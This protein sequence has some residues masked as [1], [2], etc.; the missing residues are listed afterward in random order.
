MA[1]TLL[2]ILLVTSAAA[3][4][5]LVFRWPPAPAPSAR[6]ARPRPDKKTGAFQLDNPGR[7][8]S[9]SDTDKLHPPVA[10]HSLDSDEDYEWVRPNTI[11]DRS[12]SFSRP[13]TGQQS[14]P[15]EDAAY[16]PEEPT[17]AEEFDPLFGYSSEF[18]AGLLCPRR[19]LCHQKF[20]LIVDDLAFIGHPVCA[21]DDEIWRFKPEKTKRGSSRG[22]GSR[23]RQLSQLDEAD[24]Q[25]TSTGSEQRSSSSPARLQ[26]FHLVI[27]LDLP[28]KS[29][30]SSGDVAKYF[31][32][33]YEQIA[34]TVTA[35][36]FQ[37]QVLS[38]FVEK[39]CDKLASLKDE[40]ASNCEP[41]ESY[42]DHALRES[43]IAPAIK[44]LYEAIKSS[45]M[46]HITIHNIPIELQLPPYLDHLLHSEDDY[47][48]DFVDRQEDDDGGETNAWDKEMGFG[49]R[50]PALAPW[51]SLLLLD[52]HSEQTLDPQMGV[53][54]AQAE[55]GDH[56]LAEGL[57][58][59]LETTSVTLSL[60]DMASLLDWDL[61]S[62][63]YP[64]V[65][66]LVLHRRAKIVDTVHNGLKTVFTIAPK[67][68]TH[69]SVLIQDFKRD[70]PQSGVMPLAKILS[71]ISTSTSKQSDNHFFAAVVKSK[72]LVGLYHD[73]VLWMLKRD[74]LITLHLRI[75]VV[76]TAE[77]KYHVRMQRDMQ[78]SKR[79][80]RRLSSFGAISD[81]LPDI[82][83]NL[84]PVG[85]LSW[86][87]L[88]PK[89]ARRQTRRLPSIGSGYSRTSELLLDDDSD[90]GFDFDDENE[91]DAD[92][93]DEAGVG[94]GTEEDTL[95]P[96]MIS[97]PGRATPLQRKWLSAMSEDKEEHIAYRFD[98]I[99][100]YFDGKRTDDEILHRAEI[101]RKQ[102]REVLHHY[103][104]YL[105]TFLHPS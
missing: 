21:E 41:L 56:A 65:R 45:T 103:E 38:N 92:D 24:D 98:Q 94:W 82:R 33:I 19:S 8:A 105:Q 67:F 83:G 23:N 74:L 11:R 91:K 81:T 7:A 13:S 49:W 77:I 28:D 80:R 27:V 1:E 90:D 87:S 15:S 62:Q 59:F 52:N 58:K 48:L 9:F 61:E 12:M 42:M 40:Y 70:F 79:S 17:A 85:R 96:T 31:D 3:G 86:L 6:L 47:H 54:E 89:S 29:S 50:L 18:L 64:I 35:V 66:W 88:S 20:E 46:A 5:N 68:E 4:S 63:V 34:F 14:A 69:L 39:E 73:V 84:P 37:E 16:D 97:D 93:S 104:E 95:T 57:I 2:A 75:R 32:I 71:T 99:N 44:T 102:L 10:E 101:S 51:K 36:L 53:N 60:Y 43:S 72:D 55:S 100:Q 30:S 26:K 76:A 22:R 25:E 78:R